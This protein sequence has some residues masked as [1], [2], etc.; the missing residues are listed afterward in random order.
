M[1]YKDKE[2]QRQADKAR[3]QRRRDVIKAKGV[4][5]VTPKPEGVT[6]QGSTPSGLTPEPPVYTEAK[7]LVDQAAAH[8]AKHGGEVSFKTVKGKVQDVHVTA[9]L[10]G[11]GRY[12]VWPNQYKP[13]SQLAK[14]KFN[15]VPLPGDADYTGCADNHP[16]WPRV[17]G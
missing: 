6:G 1:A 16:E 5:N 12:G 13:A 10:V 15:I 8:V 9:G 17:T 7:K 4:T 3:Q 2:K 14:G 11:C